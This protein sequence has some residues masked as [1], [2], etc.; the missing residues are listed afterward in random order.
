MTKKLST[1]ATLCLASAALAATPKPATDTQSEYTAVPFAFRAA[2]QMLPAGEYKVQHVPLRN[3][4][5]LINHETGKRVV[6][7]RSMKP[8]VPGKTYLKFERTEGEYRLK[9]AW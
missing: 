9:Q 4:S 5:I 6:F 8:S 3:E 2:G 7:M 1:L